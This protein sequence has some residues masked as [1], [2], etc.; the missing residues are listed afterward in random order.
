MFYSSNYN[1]LTRNTVPNSDY[2]IYL[3]S[4]SDNRIHHN[5]LIDNRIHDNH[6]ANNADHNAYDSNGTNQ[7]DSGSKGNYYS[8]YTGTDNNTDGIGDTHHPIPGSSGSIDHFPLMSPWTGD[9]SLKG[10][11]NHDNQI[12]SAD[13]AIALLLAATGARDPV[14]D[15]SGDDRVTSLDALMILQAAAE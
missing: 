14:A 10:D 6:W 4:S 11:L 13:A 8:D 5:S 1:A 9:T 7:W 12:T 3:S 15:V 2:G